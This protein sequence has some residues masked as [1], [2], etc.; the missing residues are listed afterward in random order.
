MRDHGRRNERQGTIGYSPRTSD[1]I[2]PRK[3]YA[4]VLQAKT[5]YDAAE[6]PLSE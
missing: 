4:T 2:R 5:K 6:K 1:S 3:I